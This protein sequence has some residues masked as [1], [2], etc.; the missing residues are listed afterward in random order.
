MKQANKESIL[1]RLERL[2]AQEAESKV[3][4][5]CALICSDHEAGTATYALPGL[6]IRLEDG[7]IIGYELER[8]I[9]GACDHAYTAA[10]CAG[11]GFHDGTYPRDA[12]VEVKILYRKPE[13]EKLTAANGSNEDVSSRPS[14]MTS[15]DV[16]NEAVY[17]PQLPLIGSLADTVPYMLHESFTLRLVGEYFQAYLRNE[18]LKEHVK[19]QKDS[20]TRRELMNQGT[21]LTLYLGCL[22]DRAKRLGI[23]FAD[24]AMP[25][26]PVEDR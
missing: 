14:A 3:F 26:A 15:P 16:K 18:K 12:A 21:C 25:M 2:S 5:N 8:D 1:E 6:H 20:E 9:Q 19:K 4:R 10:Y 11:R 17:A 24:Y 13:R 7:A 22:R 23:D